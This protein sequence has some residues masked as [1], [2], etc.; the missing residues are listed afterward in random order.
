MIKYVLLFC[1]LSVPVH[2]APCFFNMGQDHCLKNYIAD[3]NLNDI[4]K[5]LDK[6]ANPNSAFELALNTKN[7]AVVKLLLNHG[8]DAERQTSVGGGALFYV[9]HHKIPLAETLLNGGANP[10]AFDGDGNLLLTRAVI[11]Y[12]NF[13]FARLLLKHGAKINAVDANGDSPLVKAVKLNEP[14]FTVNFLLN[15]G[16]N[17]NEKLQNGSPLLT[18]AVLDKGKFDTARALLRYGA[19]INA[20]DKNG[21]TALMR[22]LEERKSDKTVVFLLENKANAKIDGVF[23]AGLEQDRSTKILDLLLKN[24]A[25]VNER[26]SN[27]RTPLFFACREKS[28]SLVSWLLQKGAS[29]TLA[30]KKGATTLMA[31]AWAHQPPSVLKALLAKGVKI[32]ARDAAGETAI[33]YAADKGTMTQKLETIDFLQKN[34]AKI[35]EVS[36]NGKTLTDMLRSDKKVIGDMRYWDL[37]AKINGG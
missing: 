11:R 15:S 18:Y 34:G 24:G 7:S 2:A 6:G 27:G 19:K 29:A 3:Q 22:A 10:N 21:K 13:D 9:L 26:S 20:T 8:A 36:K 32:N 37:L 28:A 5:S 23:L 31:A 25:N 12:G 1:L 33:F 16:A 35:N 14:L 17:P 30:T 4:R